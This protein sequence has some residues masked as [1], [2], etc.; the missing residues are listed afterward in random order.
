MNLPPE[1]EKAMHTLHAIN[2]SKR[3]CHILDSN[4]NPCSINKNEAAIVTRT[5]KGWMWFCHRCGESGFKSAKSMSY[6][7]TIKELQAKGKQKIKE[8]KICTLPSDAVPLKPLKNMDAW[9]WIWKYQISNNDVAFYRFHWSDSYKRVIIPIYDGSTL[10]GWCGRDIITKNKEEREK[11]KISKYLIRKDMNYGRIYFK[12]SEASNTIVLVEDILSA[13][14]VHNAT[15]YGTIALLTT[16]IDSELEQELIGKKVIVWLDSNAFDKSVNIVMRM[17][18]LGIDAKY[19]FTEK[20]PKEYYIR[21]IKE[22][23]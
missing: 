4:D 11:K 17:Q 18:Q 12:I 23:I 13:I 7:D 19:V 22:E 16:S 9:H 15:H 5:S 8:M 2:E 10:I 21:E 14:K 3:V 6:N 1:I 20:D